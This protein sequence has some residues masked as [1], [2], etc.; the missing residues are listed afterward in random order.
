MVFTISM[1]TTWVPFISNMIFLFDVYCSFCMLMVN[2]EMIQ[3]WRWGHD[4]PVHSTI[5]EMWKAVEFRSHW[6]FDSVKTVLFCFE[7]KHDCFSGRSGNIS[8]KFLL[9]REMECDLLYVSF[10]KYCSN[11]WPCV[12]IFLEIVL[13][14]LIDNF[15]QNS[16]QLVTVKKSISSSCQNRLKH[17]QRINGTPPII[18]TFSV[19]CAEEL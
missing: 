3:M 19:Y 2:E 4:T 14:M 7:S 9:F 11:T 1:R 17:G 13:Y 8:S 15:W 5:F 18:W 16:A 10:V 6:T 12:R